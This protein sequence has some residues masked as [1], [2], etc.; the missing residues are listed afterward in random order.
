MVYELNIFHSVVFKWPIWRVST[1]GLN[2]TKWH[3]ASYQKPSFK[4]HG[5]KRL[6]RKKSQQKVSHGWLQVA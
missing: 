3:A 1:K 4:R 2:L 5:V 6:P